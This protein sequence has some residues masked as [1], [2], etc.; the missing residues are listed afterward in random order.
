MTKAIDALL[1]AVAE[2]APER[3]NQSCLC[4][5]LDRDELALQ[6]D[7]EAGELGFFKA[8]TEQ[9]P[10]LFSNV[11]VFL[12]GSAMAEMCEVVEAIE[13]TAQLPGYREAV[14]A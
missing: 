10:N 3:L 7:R 5:T 8:L 1:P 12:S 13:T 11:P 6:L 2:L 4:I 9:R 14:L